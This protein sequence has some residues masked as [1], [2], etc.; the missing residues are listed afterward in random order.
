MRDTLNRF[1]SSCDM[2]LCLLP[3]CV[4]SAFSYSYLRC[5]R[6][7]WWTALHQLYFHQFTL[8]TNSAFLGRYL[9]PA[10]LPAVQTTAF[11]LVRVDLE[12][13]FP[14][15]ATR[16]T[17]GGEIWRGGV[18]N[19]TPPIGAWVGVGEPQNVSLLKFDNTNAPPGSIPCTDFTKFLGFV[20]S[21]TANANFKIWWDILKRFLSYRCLNSRCVPPPEPSSGET[22]RARCKK[23]RTFSTTTQS[24]GSRTLHSVGVGSKSVQYK[25]LTTIY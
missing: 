19:L 2:P 10:W 23:V 7:S 17:H 6:W 1:F 20:G 12:V 16:C 22:I 8:S 13:F 18:P 25:N 11:R 14:A 4:F 21:S 24:I 9:L 5:E 3:L 15:G